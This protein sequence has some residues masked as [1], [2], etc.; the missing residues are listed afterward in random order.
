M[1]LTELLLAAVAE[2]CP[3]ATKP[4]PVSMFYPCGLM[5]FSFMTTLISKHRHTPSKDYNFLLETALRGLQGA[6]ITSGRKVAVFES[7]DEIQ[8]LPQHAFPRSNFKQTKLH[9]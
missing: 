7:E 6:N 5:S 1:K 2:H 8:A 9:S 4:I 3:Q